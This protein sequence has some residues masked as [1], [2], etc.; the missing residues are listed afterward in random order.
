[1]SA[2]RRY[3]SPSAWKSS[4]RK[5]EEPIFA[6]PA[7]SARPF[8]FLNLLPLEAVQSANV[9]AKQAHLAFRMEVVAQKNGTA[10][11]RE[12]GVQ[13]QSIRVLESA[14]TGAVQL[15]NVGA[16]E[17]HF[18]FGLEVVVQEERDRSLRVPRSVPGHSVLESAATGAVQLAD[19]GAK[20]AHFAFGLEVRRSGQ[21]HAEPAGLSHDRGRPTSPHQ[22]AKDRSDIAGAANPESP[23]REAACPAARNRR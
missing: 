10:D 19:V 7:F 20:Q 15:A 13:C 18:A 14:A 8:G 17:A 16:K 3:T 6:R 23:H 4:F 12:C 5:T 21:R 1:M 11:L 2:P 9:G 22:G